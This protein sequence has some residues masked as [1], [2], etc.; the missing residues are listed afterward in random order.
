MREI[1]K[2][3]SGPELT[4]GFWHKLRD[5]IKNWLGKIKSRSDKNQV[6]QPGVQE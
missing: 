4:Q 6:Q 1:F 5:N 3:E 2:A